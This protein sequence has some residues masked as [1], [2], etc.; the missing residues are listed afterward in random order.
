MPV[1]RKN[2]W[3]WTFWWLGNIQRSTTHSSTVYP[4][5]MKLHIMYLDVASKRDRS[6]CRLVHHFIYPVRIINTLRTWDLSLRD[7]M[8]ERVHQNHPE[9]A[10]LVMCGDHHFP[11]QG[12]LEVPFLDT[13]NITSVLCMYSIPM[14]PQIV[15][16]SQTSPIDRVRS[17]QRARL[18]VAVVNANDAANLWKLRSP[19]IT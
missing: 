1:L 11:Q 3:Y 13:Q 7:G 2:D 15:W 18:Q 8:S 10:M 5:L 12:I 6:C 14:I 19:F 16:E 4:S 9:G 17:C